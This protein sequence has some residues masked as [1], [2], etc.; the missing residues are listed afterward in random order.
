MRDEMQHRKQALVTDP[1]Q[2]N[3]EAWTEAR[4]L[5]NSVIM[6][7]AAKR[8]YFLQQ[9]DFEK[10]E[11]TGHLLALVA[12]EQRDPSIITAIRSTAGE[13]HTPNSDILNDFHHFYNDLYA[14]KTRHAS[15][16]LTLFLQNCPFPQ[17]SDAE[18]D[19][20]NS[21]ITMTELRRHWRRPHIINLQAQMVSRLRCTLARAKSFFH[22]C[23]RPYL[24]LLRRNVYL[25]VCRR[26]L[27]WYFTNQVRTDFCRIHT[28]RFLY[29][30]WTL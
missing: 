6:S 15:S 7:A 25:T 8:R 18:R 10:R 4:S 16:E 22:T 1:S 26:P 24:R 11:N 5:Y 12:R 28:I 21:P 13:L 14:S 23:C 17:L 19:T 27:Y 20:L 9:D 3:H 2:S 30:T 29:W